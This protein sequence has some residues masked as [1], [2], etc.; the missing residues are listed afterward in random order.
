MPVLTRVPGL[1]SSN[2]HRR[3]ATSVLSCDGILRRS[4]SLLLLIPFLL[5]FNVDRMGEASLIEACA[6]PLFLLTPPLFCVGVTRRNL[7]RF[8]AAARFRADIVSVP[9]RLPP[10]Q[11]SA[12][13]RFSTPPRP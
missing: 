2:L 13:V 3:L 10:A 9:C 12:A 5:Y 8:P 1:S 6:L 4:V 11:H 7:A